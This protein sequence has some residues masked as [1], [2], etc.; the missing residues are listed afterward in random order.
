LPLTELQMALR[1][2]WALKALMYS[3]WAR[4]MDWRERLRQV[5]DGAGGSGF[6]IAANDGGDEASEGGAEIA[7]GEVVGGEEVG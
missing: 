4:R 5:G 6:Y 7:G 3:C 1:Q 2:P